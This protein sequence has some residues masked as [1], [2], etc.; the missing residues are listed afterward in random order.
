LDSIRKYPSST[1]FPRV[2]EWIADEMDAVKVT[3]PIYPFTLL[4][5]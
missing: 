3:K 2:A 1:P 5:M 4:L